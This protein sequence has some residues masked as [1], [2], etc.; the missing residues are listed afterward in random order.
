MLQEKM[1]NILLSLILASSAAIFVLIPQA[2]ALEHAVKSLLSRLALSE[3]TLLLIVLP[4]LIFL[5]LWYF[6]FLGR[7]TGYKHAVLFFVLQSC[8]L[9]SIVLFLVTWFE[10]SHIIL[11]SI[12]TGS[13]YLFLREQRQDSSRWLL[14]FIA[15][16]ACFYLS[17][18]D[19]GFQYLHPARYGDLRDI[20]I[21]SAS[22]LFAL[23]VCIPPEKR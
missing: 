20:F 10:L 21:N 16:L 17:L 23:F 18:L 12:F 6:I 9:L 19:E 2:R 3:S 14:A 13:L 5:A 22:G 11:F 15:F 1:Q 7:R 4:G 8:V